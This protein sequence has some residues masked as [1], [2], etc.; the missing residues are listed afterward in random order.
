MAKVTDWALYAPYFTESEFRCKH[1]DLC[2]VDKQFL[3]RLLALR[4]E[5]GKPMRIT[6]GYRDA[7]HPI[8]ARKTKP[9]AHATGKACDVA[10][11]PQD[12]FRLISLAIKHGFTG[13]GVSQRAD[14]P[15][16]IHLDTIEGAPRPNFWSY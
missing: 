3:D 15:R 5:Y 14:Q 4:L 7:R 16:F 8:E 1:T 2:N 10:C 9:G 12:A 6:S 13:I 11:T